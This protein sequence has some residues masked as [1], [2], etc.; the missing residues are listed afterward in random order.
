[1]T[2]N[3]PERP[4]SPHPLG[5]YLPGIMQADDLTSRWVAG[6]DDLLTPILWILESLEVYVDPRL[7]PPD[8]LRWLAGWVGAEVREDLPAPQQRRLVADTADLHGRRG[9]VGALH[10]VLETATSALV[11]V[12]E[13]G[14]GVSWSSSPRDPMPARTRED[15][16]VRV[17]A[18]HEEALRVAQLV[19]EWCPAHV[20][21]R[22]EFVES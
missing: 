22:V 13:D 8:L 7:A 12:V 18:S 5:S 1:M 14:G 15:L 16:L 21:H 3:P 9:T 11:D 19:A 2:V 10:Q 4:I 17:K 6:L 20:P